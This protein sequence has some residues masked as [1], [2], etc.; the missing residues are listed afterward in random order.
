MN[1]GKAQSAFVQFQKA[2]QIDPDNKNALNG[3]GL[4]YFELEEFEKAKELFLK[5]V[6]I[7][8]DF[9]DAYNNLGVTYMKIGQWTEAIES[10]KKALSN[11]LYQ[12]VERAFYNCGV[13]YYRTG[14]YEL[15]MN[16]FKSSIKRVPSFPLPYY[17]LALAYNKS[18]RYGD[19]AAIITKAI[20]MDPAYKGD[21]KKFAEEINLKLLTARG[22]EEVDLKDYLEILKY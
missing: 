21:R 12:N 7:D 5:T 2:L 14:Q 9:S 18:G 19:A 20:E 11:P 1:E 6:Y 13:A 10:F 16:E 4:V 8:P 15:A 22:K 3:L 17:G